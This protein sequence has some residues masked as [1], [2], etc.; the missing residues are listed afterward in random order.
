MACDRLAYLFHHR[1]RLYDYRDDIRHGAF[2]NLAKRSQ[3]LITAIKN[4][5][6]KHG[7]PP[8]KLEQLVPEFLSSIPHTGMGAYPDYE[9][10][11]G[12]GAACHDNP[13][14]IEVSTPSGGINFD[15]F[16]YFP[17]QNYPKEGYGGVLEKIEDWAYVHE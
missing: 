1:H 2:I 17:K 13:W 10:T 16:F 7:G 11:G 12:C 8:S 6:I 14:M 9:Y 4:Y 5:E 15:R 3:P